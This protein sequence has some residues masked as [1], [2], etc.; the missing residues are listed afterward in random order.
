MFTRLV[1]AG[2]IDT[3][4]VVDE[5]EVFAPRTIVGICDDSLDAWRGVRGVRAWRA[6][7]VCAVMDVFTMLHIAVWMSGSGI[8]NHP[9]LR[10]SIVQSGQ[11]VIF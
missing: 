4:A 11:P 10:R 5:A 7:G 1:W 2:L 8:Y 6:C 3:V 9:F